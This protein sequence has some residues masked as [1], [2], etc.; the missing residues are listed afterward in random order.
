MDKVLGEITY[1]FLNSN[2]CTDEVW[3]WISNFIPHFVIDVIRPIII[4]II[5]IIN[6]LSMLGLS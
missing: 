2:G 5:I 4:I 3:E 1:P 6:Y